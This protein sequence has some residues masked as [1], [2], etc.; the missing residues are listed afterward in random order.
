MPCLWIVLYRDEPAGCRGE[1]EAK[2]ENT[3]MIHSGDL[4][5]VDRAISE[6]ARWEPDTVW[7]G[8]SN[9]NDNGEPVG[10]TASYYPLVKYLGHKLL[11][12]GAE[13]DLI[14]QMM[15]VVAAKN[16]L[17]TVKRVVP[18]NLIAPEEQ[19]LISQL[20]DPSFQL[21]GNLYCG[22]ITTCGS[23]VPSE[24][25]GQ[26]NSVVPCAVPPSKYPPFYGPSTVFPRF[27]DRDALTSVHIPYIDDFIFR[28]ED[29]PS[30]YPIEATEEVQ[31]ALEV[32]ESQD[33]VW[34]TKQ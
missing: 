11:L 17:V 27:V 1:T 9:W 23:L 31:L 6:L 7:V 2:V 4:E 21:I 15:N 22:E 34:S 13:I 28:A 3:E 14:E 24:D 32:L 20:Q 19:D 26:E 5:I 8:E 30:E 16:G 10:K 25:W 12:I 33:P 18:E 29:G